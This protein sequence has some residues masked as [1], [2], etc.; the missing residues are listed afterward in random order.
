MCLYHHLYKNFFLIGE[1]VTLTD[2]PLI[3]L[4]APE[5]V[6][7]FIVHETLSKLYF[8]RSDTAAIRKIL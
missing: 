2:S 3:E 5:D 7:L 4:I 8:Y 1:T 6:P